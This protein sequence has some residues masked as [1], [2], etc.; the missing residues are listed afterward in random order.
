MPNLILSLSRSISS[1]GHHFFNFCKCSL[2]IFK[3]IRL[4]VLEKKIVYGLHGHG[5]NLGYVT[6]FTNF[7]TIIALIGQEKKM[8]KNNGQDIAPGQGQTTPWGQ[9]PFQ[10]I[11]DIKFDLIVQA[12][13]EEK[14]FENGAHQRKGALSANIWSLRLR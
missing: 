3:I 7:C 8:F 4:L 13:L 12:V 5:D 2:T 9:N 14:N 6:G 1:K 10:G 11:L